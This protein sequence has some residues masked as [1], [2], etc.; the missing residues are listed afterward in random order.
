M[1]NLKQNHPAVSFGQPFIQHDS[2]HYET[3]GFHLRLSDNAKTHSSVL[4]REPVAVTTRVA[5]LQCSGLP[6]AHHH[7]PNGIS[8]NCTG[9]AKVKESVAVPFIVLRRPPLSPR[10]FHW[11]VLKLAP[12]PLVVMKVQLYNYLTHPLQQSLSLEA[13]SRSS[14]DITLFTW[15][16]SYSALDLNWAK[17]NQAIHPRNVSYERW[18]KH[19]LTQHTHVICYAT[20]FS[21]VNQPSS[22][23]FWMRSQSYMQ[24]SS[25]NGRSWYRSHDSW[26][27]KPK[28]VT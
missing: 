28:L 26:L 23:L 5:L 22:G 15:T 11:P 21:F 16:R 4:R 17:Q 7:F 12:L 25:F 1:H 10:I 2:D 6:V 19:S 13:D 3:E 24:R 14:V 18:S 20:N 9:D 8:T 27:K